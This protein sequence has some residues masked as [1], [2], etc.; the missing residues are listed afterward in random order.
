MPDE[1]DD[2]PDDPLGIMPPRPANLEEAIRAAEA[3]E[4]ITP[5]AT[6]VVPGGLLQN[7]AR[8]AQISL[9]ADVTGDEL[10]NLLWWIIMSVEQLRQQRAALDPRA[11]LLIPRR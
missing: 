10:V 4:N 1:P 5:M 9:P 6:F 3:A 7:P 8:P 2:L 11:R